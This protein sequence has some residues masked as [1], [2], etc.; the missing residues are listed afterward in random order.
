MVKGNLSVLLIAH[1]EEKVIG[2]MIEG[3]IASYGSVLMEI[4][5]VDDSSTDRTSSIVESWAQKTGGKVR[6]IKK[7]PPSGVG[8]A[9]KTG[10]R[11]IDPN[12][13]YVLTMDGDFIKNIDEVG[14]LIEKAE[15]N[16][17]DG[18][19][20]SR[21]IE[22]GQLVGYPSNKKIMNRLWHFIVR[23]LFHIKQKDLTNNFKLFK[24]NIV[25][26][27]PWKSNDFAINAETGLLPIL[28][29]YRI[30]EVPVSW[31]GRDEEMGTSKFRL[32]VRVGW[33]YFKVI[34]Y[35]IWFLL[36]KTKKEG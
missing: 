30:C 6:I 12:C 36:S 24:A 14:R 13:G 25:R 15:H 8:R 28:A 2:K 4:V 5:V 34:I 7:G 19:F 3:L 1:N 23:R 17:Y 9:M 11:N 35:G 10:F 31:I 33:G 27:L 16:G 29:G 20:G 21:F 22:G 26:K 32:S 18:V